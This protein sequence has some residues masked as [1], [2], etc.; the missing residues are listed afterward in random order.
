MIPCSKVVIDVLQLKFIIILSIKYYKISWINTGRDALV[1]LRRS[2]GSHSCS[3]PLPIVG[4]Y[5]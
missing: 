2:V 1:T 5:F 4:R 3:E